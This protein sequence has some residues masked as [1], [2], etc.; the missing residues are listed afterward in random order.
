[1]W[2]ALGRYILEKNLRKKEGSEEKVEGKRNERQQDIKA[3]GREIVRLQRE[4]EALL[5]AQQASAGRGGH[6]QGQRIAANR[7]DIASL[8]QKVAAMMSSQQSAYGAGNGS[9]AASGMAHPLTSDEGP[10]PW[11]TVDGYAREIAACP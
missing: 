9:W 11:V 8:Q 7:S 3:I 5:S 4:Y 1:M 6:T 2:A 10:E